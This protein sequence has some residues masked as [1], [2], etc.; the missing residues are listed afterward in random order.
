MPP[1]APA[2][3]CYVG[4]GGLGANAATLPAT[5][6][7][8]G[9]FRYDAPTPFEGITDGLSQTLL[10]GESRNEVGPWL[11]GG[12]S[13]VRALDDADGALPLVGTG[14]QFGG[15]F[16]GVAH[17]ALCD[18][19]VRAFTNRADPRVLYG[20]STIAG[21]NTDPVLVD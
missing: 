17:F 12:S 21:K 20:L 6:P 1:D 13:T 5:A 8:A 9:A 10:F 16:P 15:Y 7:R 2:I 3:T 14:G 18:G 19:G 4:V 11:R